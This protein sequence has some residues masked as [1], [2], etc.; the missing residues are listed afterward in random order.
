MRKDYLAVKLVNRNFNIY[1]IVLAILFVLLG[2]GTSA[3]SP[4]TA[5]N[6]NTVLATPS[7]YVEG[8][9]TYN[10]GSG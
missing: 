4:V 8:G 5:I 9:S 6:T 1:R 7:S 3:Q 10:W 2:I